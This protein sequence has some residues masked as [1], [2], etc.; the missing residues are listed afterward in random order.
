[1]LLSRCHARASRYVTSNA[2]LTI[3]SGVCGEVTALEGIAK[4]SLSWFVAIPRNVSVL[5]AMV[6]R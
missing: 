2:S 5:D 4:V 1:M 6:K 3:S